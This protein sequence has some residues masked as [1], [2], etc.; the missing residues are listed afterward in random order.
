LT[1]RL[2]I[3]VLYYKWKKSRERCHFVIRCVLLCYDPGET[4]DED[5]HSGCTA[6]RDEV[7]GYDLAYPIQQG[8]RSEEGQIFWSENL[9]VFHPSQQ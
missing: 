7:L 9:L 1:K 5:E 2:G 6:V 4:T 8:G 3:A